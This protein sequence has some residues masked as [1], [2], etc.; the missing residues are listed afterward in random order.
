M[1]CNCGF[2]HQPAQLFCQTSSQSILFL[3]VDFAQMGCNQNTGSSYGRINSEEPGGYADVDLEQVICP[4]L[5]LVFVPL[6]S[7]IT[8]LKVC[9]DKTSEAYLGGARK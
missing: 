4:L 6:L 5:V 8:C 3:G 2:F 7:G 1:V 9:G